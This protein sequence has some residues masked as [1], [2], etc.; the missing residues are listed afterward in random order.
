[1]SIARVQ[2]VHGKNEQINVE[3]AADFDGAGFGHVCDV[4][5]EVELQILEHLHCYLA[6]PS[7]AQVYLTMNCKRGDEGQC[8]GTNSI[9][10]LPASRPMIFTVESP[11]SQVFAPVALAQIADCTWLM[12]EWKIVIVANFVLPASSG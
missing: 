11:L 10:F 8:Q 9:R 6:I 5:S 4:S 2:G 1:M 12:Y 7:A 3:D